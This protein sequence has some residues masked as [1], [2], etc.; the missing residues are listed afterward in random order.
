MFQVVLVECKKNGKGVRQHHPKISPVDLE[1][2]AEYFNHDHITLPDPRCLQQSMIFYIIYYFCHRGRENL[3]QMTKDTFKLVVEP[4]GTECLIQEID[5]MDKN[6]GVD[7]YN[8]SNEG[9]MY[10]KPGM[11]FYIL[12]NDPKIHSIQCKMSNH[13]SRPKSEFTVM[14]SDKTFQF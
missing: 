14:P 8:K 5:E 3:Y 1:C 9:K 4:D 6:H 12:Q 13:R 7:D 10:C 11:T 2:I